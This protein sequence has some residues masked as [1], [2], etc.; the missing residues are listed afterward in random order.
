MPYWKTQQESLRLLYIVISTISLT[1]N[2]LWK[3]SLLSPPPPPF[4]ILWAPSILPILS[5][6]IFRILIIWMENLLTRLVFW[7]S[8]CTFHDNN[9]QSDSPL[10]QDN[11][12]MIGANRVFKGKNSHLPKLMSLFFLSTPGARFVK[13]WKSLVKKAIQWKMKMVSLRWILIH[14][15]HWGYTDL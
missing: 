13:G 7:K 14:C 10:L 15:F 1:F 2:F 11:A 9:P 12:C 8:F 5:T 3:Q 6:T 4:F